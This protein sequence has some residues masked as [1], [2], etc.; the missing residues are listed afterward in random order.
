[1]AAIIV[2]G[3]WLFY[4]YQ[5]FTFHTP[6]ITVLNE[7]KTVKAGQELYTQGGTENLTD[8]IKIDVFLQIVDGTVVNFPEF[9]YVSEKGFFKPVRSIK[10]PDYLPPGKYFLKADIAA[11]VNPLR[12]VLIT[13]VSEDFIVTK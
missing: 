4:P 13:R 11:H 12:T 9:S 8:N 6:K 2:G 10:I 3:Y 1:M 7:N 5:I